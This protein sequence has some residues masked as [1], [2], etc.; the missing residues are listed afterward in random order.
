M[1]IA[2]SSLVVVGALLLVAISGCSAR[3]LSSLHDGVLAASGAASSG[4][5][6]APDAG[7]SMS[8]GG[9]G[10]AG[11]PMSSGGAGGAVPGNVGGAGVAALGPWS[12]DSE[13]D[14]ASGD[15]SAFTART[16]LGWT[17]QGESLPLG[18][19]VFTGTLDRER[20]IVHVLAATPQS[21]YPGDPVDL[22]GYTFRVLARSAS[23]DTT[24]EL[25]AIERSFLRF[26][27][28][29]HTLG[30]QWTQLALDFSLRDPTNPTYNPSQ[31]MMVG[32]KSGRS[33]IWIDRI[34][35]AKETGNDAGAP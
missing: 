16:T 11:G 31:T 26:T 34:W 21:P 2:S 18:S 7:G 17:A 5:A 22:S 10:G 1:P 30:T 14:T 12:F 33:E 35:L 32:I 4:G 3:D 6:S 9:A 23:E 15:W 27:G 24:L 13:A 20:E 8:S 28:E 19:L 25:Y 29:K